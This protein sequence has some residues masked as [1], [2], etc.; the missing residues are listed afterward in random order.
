[1]V[2]DGWKPQY[3]KLVRRA[4]VDRLVV[5]SAT[6]LDFLADVPPLRTLEVHHH[7]LK[8]VRG[9]EAQPALRT[10]SLNAYYRTP[11]DFSRFRSLEELH[12]DWGP[13]AESIAK[14]TSLVD[15]S[16]NRWP[17]AD[18]TPLTELR[19]LRWLRIATAPLTSLRGVEAF[20]RL[21]HARFL[22]LRRLEDIAPLEA[23]AST[24]EDLDFNTCP[25]IRSLHPLRSL[26]R[27]RRLL[28]LNC[29][30][31]ESLA[32]IEGLSL[33]EFLFYDSTNI[34]D[35]DLS[36]LLRMPLLRDT[37]FQD[38][39]HYSHRRDAILDALSERTKGKS[40]GPFDLADYPLFA[41]PADLAEKPRAEWTMAEA[42]RYFDW[43]MSVLPERVARVT[44]VLGLDPKGSPDDVL[45]AAGEQMARILPMSGVSTEGRIE[46]SVLRGHEVETPSGPL[47]TVV[48]Y[49]LAAD[50][51][52]LMAT[53]LLA[54][55]PELRWEIVTRP[56]S[57][58]DYHL[59]TLQ[60]FG[61][62][63]MDPIRIS[64]VT[65]LRV[66]DSRGPASAWRD[67]YH[68]WREDCG[69]PPARK[70]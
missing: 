29:G 12:L 57:D 25:R 9:I 63:H 24:L 37:S 41:P 26:T 14:V 15:L 28:V 3:A 51:G 65:A 42:R 43:L 47:V 30:E 2:H 59:P 70:G 34:R 36:V 19:G 49:A 44:R 10:I 38:R 69:P 48:G 64:V 39:R 33:E 55:C 67:I 27:L 45:L 23:V 40:A 35:G 20:E 58:V 46:R 17:G 13:G 6:N 11:L 68:V 32:P 50:L 4:R 60:P 66:L 18:L 62:V 61:P 31:I 53:M 8:D 16:V 5:T 1:M 21:E 56:R 7:P 22:E 54:A 52:L